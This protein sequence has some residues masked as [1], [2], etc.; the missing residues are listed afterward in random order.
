MIKPVCLEVQVLIGRGCNGC[1]EVHNFLRESLGFVLTME[2]AGRKG[3]YDA[4]GETKIITEFPADGAYVT[5]KYVVFYQ[6]TPNGKVDTEVYRKDN[7]ERAFRTAIYPVNGKRQAIDF[8]EMQYTGIVVEDDSFLILEKQMDKQVG[9]YL[10][11]QDK[12]I[13]IG[14]NFKV[15]DIVMQENFIMIESDYGVNF[16][17]WISEYGIRN[18]SFNVEVEII[19]CTEQEL[20][21]RTIDGT[22]FIY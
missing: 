18:I 13:L 16:I 22:E 14:R 4:T 9:I 20:I 6:N 15:K 12:G 2:E 8:N 17:E 1:Q 3:L 5:E 7:L 21:I 19:R 11:T 10:I